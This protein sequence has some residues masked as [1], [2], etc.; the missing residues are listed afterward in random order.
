MR[1]RQVGIDGLCYHRYFGQAYPGV[2]QVPD[3]A[4]TAADFVD[5]AVALGADEDAALTESIADTRNVLAAVT[6]EDPAG[7]ATRP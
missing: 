4:M 7:T 3:R 6:G 2:E 5:R 1:G